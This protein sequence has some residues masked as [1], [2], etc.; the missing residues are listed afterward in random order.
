MNLLLLISLFFT[1]LFIVPN[2]VIQKFDNY[3]QIES[4]S[5]SL[6]PKKIDLIIDNEDIKYYQKNKDVLANYKKRKE[7]YPTNSR[8]STDRQDLTNNQVPTG[9]QDFTNFQNEQIENELNIINNI[10]LDYER[11][12]QNVHDTLVQK[13]IK[14]QYSNLINSN[15]KVDIQ[16]IINYSRSVLP[17]KTEDLTFVLNKIQQR[18]STL[19]TLNGDTEMNALAKVWDNQDPDIRRQLLN[20]LLD[21]KNGNNHIYCPTGVVTRIVNSLNIHNPECMAKTGE[22]L[23]AELLQI[24][25]NISSS[26]SY[27]ESTFKETLRNTA[28]KE[29]PNIPKE[30]IDKELNQWIDH[31]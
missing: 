21:C 11:G 23:K 13:Q 27:D 5:S 9:R 7:E 18:N 26:D 10:I 16:E 20:E 15:D 31:I 6:I 25:S 28:Y 1:V 17:E 2:K 19:T 22:I 4:P 12:S 29:Y 8:G 30:N 14:N 24:A 3:V